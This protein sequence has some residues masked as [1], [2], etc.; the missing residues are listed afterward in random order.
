MGFGVADGVLDHRPDQRPRRRLDLAV[1][2]HGHPQLLLVGVAQLAD[3][4]LQFRA[5]PVVDQRPEPVGRLVGQADRRPDNELL[6]V[7]RNT[8][9]LG[10]GRKIGRQWLAEGRQEE[11]SRRDRVG[12]VDRPTSR[13]Q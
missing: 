6:A 5:F 3:L 1:V 11:F 4:D 7:L 10:G 9:K 2:S 12:H 13:R 8:M